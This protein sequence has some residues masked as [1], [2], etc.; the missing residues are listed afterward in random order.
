MSVLFTIVSIVI[1]NIIMT[2]KRTKETWDFL[3]KEYEGSDKIKGIQVLN[4][5]QE[6]EMQRLKET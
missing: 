4:L 5:V 6:F 3:K 2:I 1:F